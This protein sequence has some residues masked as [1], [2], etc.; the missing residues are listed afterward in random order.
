MGRPANTIALHVV[1]FFAANPEE[2]LTTGD[3]CAKTGVEQ[4][5]AYARLAPMVKRGLLARVSRQT[6]NLKLPC[7]YTAGPE[8][9]RMIGRA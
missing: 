7:L 5:A 3:I 4:G 6:G 8:L 1:A 2:E 9:L